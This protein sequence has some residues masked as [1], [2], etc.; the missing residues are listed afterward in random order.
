MNLPVF[1]PV[2]LSLRQWQL[3]Q[4]VKIQHFVLGP[5][6][7]N[8]QQACKAWNMKNALEQKAHITLCKT[9]EDCLAQARLVSEKGVLPLFW[10]CAVYYALNQFFFNNPDTFPFLFSFNFPLDNMQLCVRE[11]L[12]NKEW[13]NDWRIASHPSP[14]PLVAGLVNQATLT[15]SNAQAAKLCAGG[16]VEACITTAQAAKIHG[17]TMVHE[18]GSPN[19]VFFAGTTQHG[20]SVLQGR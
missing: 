9:P 7:T 2:P 6:G 1:S 13:N 8:M 14:A 15:T 4:V 12:A 19:M 10:T 5:V 17:L 18:F 16:E 3:A 11:E 20:V